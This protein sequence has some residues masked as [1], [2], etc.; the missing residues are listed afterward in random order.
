MDKREPPIP[1]PSSETLRRRIMA[2]LDESPCTSKDI[3]KAVGIPEKD[4]TQ[5]LLHIQRTLLSEGRKLVIAPAEC[6]K[7][8]FVFRK[9]DRLSKPGKCPLCHY[10]FISAPEFS[11]RDNKAA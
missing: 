6:R 10:Q 5:H 3:S 7:C 8:G 9:R 11:T 2:L 4:V 1:R